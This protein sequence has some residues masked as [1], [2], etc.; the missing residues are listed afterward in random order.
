MGAIRILQPALVNR[1]AAGECIE[2][3]ASVVKELVENALDA[4]AGQI[5]VTVVDGGRELIEVVDDGVGMDADDLRLC[6]EPHATSKLRDDEDLFN[7][8]TM[9]FR[10]EALAS[11]GSV[12][13]LEI[14]S[15]PADSEVGHT[16]RVEGGAVGQPRPCGAPAGTRVAVRD[17]FYCVPARRKFLRTNQTEMGHITE[18]FARLALAHPGVA[19][20]L[21][22]HRRT[23]HTLAATDDRRQRIADFYGPE[24]AE[25]LLPIRREGRGVVVEGW[26]AP[27]AE[28]RASGRW[29]YVF[30]NGRFVRDRF[31]SHAI[32]EAYRS[33]IDPSRFPIAF[34]FLTIDPAEVDV[35]VHPTKSEVRWRDANYIHAQVLAA[36]REKFLASNL[37]QPLQTQQAEQEAYRER[38]RRAMVEFFTSAAPAQRPSATAAQKHAGMAVTSQPDSAAPRQRGGEATEDDARSAGP[39]SPAR[40]DDGSTR[41]AE[42]PNLADVFAGPGSAFAP[43]GAAGF[44]LGADVATPVGRKFVQLHNAFIVA[45]TDDGLMIIDQH[46]LHER[47]L[48]E[49]L[50]ARLAAGTLESQRL[51][52]PEVVRVPA[53]R[54]EVL[55]A[56]ADLLRRLGIELTAAG[57]QT[58]A[59]HAFP[60]LL[61]RVE[62]TGFVRELLDVLSEQGAR[63]DVE[64]LIHHVLDMLACKA[65]VKAGDPLTS[66]EIAALLARRELAERSSH[67]PHGR[68][69]TLHLTLRDLQRQFAR[70]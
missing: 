68:P 21:R 9:G 24:L 52:L 55:E 18:Y 37:D 32:R 1:I 6:V 62:R 5:D 33:L 54:L 8:R 56:H 45:E 35:N 16:I 48:Y 19:F 10:G 39:C 60:S 20:T 12:A 14:T 70:R 49:E 26:V 15:R 29:E 30:V 36:L 38:V 65:A 66:D 53:D 3:P 27:P 17:L 59:L 11:I 64:S 67:C 44:G 58:V 31:V 51:L 41:S 43:S 50:R 63:P 4:G 47:I 13:R 7:I 57:P 2:R 61:G 69:T 25:V 28:S 34:V 23:I 40:P 46:A 22:H 42:A